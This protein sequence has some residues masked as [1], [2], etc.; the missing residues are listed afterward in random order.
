MKNKH[1]ASL[2]INMMRIMDELLLEILSNAY[3][4]CNTR[5]VYALVIFMNNATKL[6]NYL[7]SPHNMVWAQNH[8]K[9]ET[10]QKGHR[11][12]NGHSLVYLAFYCIVMILKPQY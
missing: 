3:I 8:L 6:I 10:Y 11:R 5:S 9:F 1:C 2:K 4:R 12:H 7:H